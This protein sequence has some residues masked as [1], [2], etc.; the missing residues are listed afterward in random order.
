[1]K[2]FLSSIA[3]F[4]FSFICF[5]AMAQ[6]QK[7]TIKVWGS[8]EM[9]KKKI[10]KAAKEAGAKSA[11]WSPDTHEL[12]VSFNVSN[13]SAT[14]IQEAI[15]KVGYDTQDFT[16]DQSAYDNLHG[17]CKYERKSSA[18]PVVLSCC[19]DATCGKDEAACKEKGCC[20]EKTCCKS[21][22]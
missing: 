19:K 4:F 3:I 15:A 7:E 10:E 9:C 17:C 11:S 14:K 18:M 8:C 2:T 13:T 5:N 1:M 20:K 12:I 22:K 16:A 6:Q 21:G